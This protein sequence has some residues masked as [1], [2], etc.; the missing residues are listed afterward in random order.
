MTLDCRFS[1]TIQA[2]YLE[3]TAASSR[4]PTI[5]TGWKTERVLVITAPEDG[6]S[7]NQRPMELRRKAAVLNVYSPRGARVSTGGHLSL[8]G[9]QVKQE[10]KRAIS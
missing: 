4:R 7:F 8:H 5:N 2:E 3:S 1:L 10:Q 6:F 9:D